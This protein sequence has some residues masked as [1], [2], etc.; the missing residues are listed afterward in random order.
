MADRPLPDGWRLVSLHQSGQEPRI[1]TA[2]QRVSDADIAR[3]DAIRVSYTSRRTGLTSFRTIHGANSKA[4]IGDLIRTVT[5][6]VSP[7]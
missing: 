6:V 2:R 4:Q 3:A 1:I 5:R 7:T